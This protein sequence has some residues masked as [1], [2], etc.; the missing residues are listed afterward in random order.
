M[1]LIFLEGFN[2]QFSVFTLVVYLLTSLVSCCF[3]SA[4][5]RPILHFELYC[6]SSHILVPL[7]AVKSWLI[8]S[9]VLRNN[10]IVSKCFC[11]I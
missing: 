9:F 11:L 5:K 8:I 3:F 4:D 6:F 10:F 2:M 7:G 1:A